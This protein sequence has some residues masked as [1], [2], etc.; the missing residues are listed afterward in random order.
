MSCIEELEEALD[1]P[2]SL[3]ALSEGCEK[4][5]KWSLVLW[6]AF[7]VWGRWTKQRCLVDQGS[8]PEVQCYSSALQGG[9]VW[10]GLRIQLQM[11]QLGS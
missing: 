4:L 11:V 5:S 9:C 8:F 6:L 2:F 1:Q 10:C 7:V 3:V